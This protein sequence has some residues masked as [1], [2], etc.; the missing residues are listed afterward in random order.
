MIRY[1]VELVRLA[2]L[3]SLEV[4]AQTPDEALAAA[5]PLLQAFAREHCVKLPGLQV[6]IKQ[7]GIGVVK[8]VTL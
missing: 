4:D 6:R 7:P 1:T 8:R 3:H 5:M 2:R